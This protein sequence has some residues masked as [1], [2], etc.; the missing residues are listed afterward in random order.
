M[1]DDIDFLEKTI[2][3]SIPSKQTVLL[4]EEIGF[5]KVYEYYFYEKPDKKYSIVD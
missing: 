3:N 2:L 4:Y 5:S 1:F